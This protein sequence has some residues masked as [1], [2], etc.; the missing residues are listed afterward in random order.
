MEKIKIENVNFLSKNEVY[1]DCFEDSLPLLTQEN[2]VNLYI[3]STDLGADKPRFGSSLTE[4]KRIN[5][6]L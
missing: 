6:I 3:K 1:F 2:V 5:K 4:T